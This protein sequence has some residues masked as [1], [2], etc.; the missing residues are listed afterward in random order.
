MAGG[1]DLLIVSPNSSG[2]LDGELEE[3]SEKIPVVFFC[4]QTVY[5]T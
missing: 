2:D 1:I 4:P 5:N 3:V